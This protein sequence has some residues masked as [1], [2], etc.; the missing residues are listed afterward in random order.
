VNLTTGTYYSIKGDSPLLWEAISTGAMVDKIAAAGAVA[1]GEPPEAS[2][3]TLE[4]FCRS[5]VEVGGDGRP[6]VESAV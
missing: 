6:N 5:L 2:A 1:T 4:G 3:G